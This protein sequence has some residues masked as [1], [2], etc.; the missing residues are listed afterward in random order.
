MKKITAS[1]KLAAKAIGLKF[2]DEEIQKL[3]A[4]ESEDELIPYFDKLSNQIPSF[5]KEHSE[6]GR[7]EIYNA[8]D[9]KLGEKF[10]VLKGIIGEEK[11]NKIKTTQGIAKLGILSDEMAEAVAEAKKA[12]QVGSSDDSKAANEKILELTRKISEQETTGKKAL[13]DK[14]KELTD[15]YETRL[16][17]EAL[18]TKVASVKD[19][20]SEYNKEEIIRGVLV[21]KV[22]ALAK[23][24]KLNLSRS[25]TGEFELL[26]Q[27]GTPWVDGGKHYGIQDLLLEATKDYVKKSDGGGQG[28]GHY[29]PAGGRQGGNSGTVADVWQA[30]AN[31]E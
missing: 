21:P 30:A 16:M 24:K 7:A 14:E 15:R 27:D 19:I 1:L 8:L 25:E 29:E 5:A 11:F 26:G 17:N 9:A 12:K 2:T 3:D 22:H 20:A 31:G 23:V 6:A 18:F 4:V 28:G 13:E 10:E